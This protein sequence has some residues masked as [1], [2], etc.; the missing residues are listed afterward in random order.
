[1]WKLSR[2][3]TRCLVKDEVGVIKLKMGRKKAHVTYSIPESV[4]R[5][6]HTKLTAG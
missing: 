1:M 5:R 4:V 2:E 6:I 3:T